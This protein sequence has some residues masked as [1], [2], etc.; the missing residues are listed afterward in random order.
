[1]NIE[2]LKS[3]E[4]DPNI[5]KKYVGISSFGKNRIVYLPLLIGIGLLMFVLM[6]I[7]SNLTETIGMATIIAM[8][9]V[10]LICFVLVKVISN[11]TKK[12]MIAETTVAPTS[13]ARKIVG[14]D[15]EMAYSCIYITGEHRHYET[16]LDEIAEK[17][18]IAIQTPQNSTDKEVANLFRPDFINPNEF[19]K[20]LP[21]AFT[22]NI[23]VWC[24]QVSFKAISKEI[25]QKIE[26]EDGKFA[27][28]AIVPENARF[29]FEYYT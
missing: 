7:F 23:I 18:D 21:L 5:V 3:L 24:K 11:A 15:N 14:N 1:M 13:I 16:L 9:I 27:M 8:C 20:K 26:D 10:S 12:K 29:L 17:I 25:N 28:V 22:D 6:A 19:A 4:K 2:K